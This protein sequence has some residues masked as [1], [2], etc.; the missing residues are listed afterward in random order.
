MEPILRQNRSLGQ[1]LVDSGRLKPSQ[2]ALALEEQHGSGELLGRILVRRG[3]VQEAD[4]VAA[5][6]GLLVITFEVAG[7]HFA[8]ETLYVREIIRA[9]AAVPVPETPGYVEGLVSL[10]DRVVPIID[11][12]KRF[13]LTPPEITEASRV[14]I[15]ESPLCLAGVLV[16]SVG[17][18]LQLPATQLEPIP[19][20][21]NGIPARFLYS[22]GRRGDECFIILNL[23]PLLASKEP[24]RLKA[25]HEGS[26]E[27]SPA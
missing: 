3:F 9:R 11:L 17:A 22:L 20:Q 14:I 1:L 13:S 16:D 15:V 8:A 26:H 4:I 24:I 10:R 23:E 7:E 25:S 5:L 27:Q 19:P 6:K 21:S 2:L 18:V 12:R